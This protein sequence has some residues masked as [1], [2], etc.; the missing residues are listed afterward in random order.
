[1]NRL[2]Y[3]ANTDG[4]A[5]YYIYDE[6]GLRQAQLVYDTATSDFSDPSNDIYYYYQGLQVELETT[7]TGTPIREFL[8]G[9][10]LDQPVAQIESNGSVYYY[11]QNALGSVV[12]LTDTTGSVVQQ[13]S[14]TVH[15]ERTVKSASGTILDESAAL[16]VYAFTGRRFDAPFGLHYYRQRY[17]SATLGR[18]ISTDPLD[19]VDG[20][21]LYAYVGGSPVNG[22]DPLGQ[23]KIELT[24][25]GRVLAEM[26]VNGSVSMVD[27]GG[28]TQTRHGKGRGAWTTT[29]YSLRTGHTEVTR[30][31]NNARSN[32][33]R[34]VATAIKEF[35]H[36]TGGSFRGEKL[37]TGILLDHLSQFNDP[38][39]VPRAPDYAS[40]WLS[41]GGGA[42]GMIGGIYTAVQSGGLSAVP[43]AFL[44]LQ[45]FDVAVAGVVQ[46]MTGES[47]RTY[48]NRGLN[49]AARQVTDDAAAAQRF[50]DIAEF[51][52]GFINIGGNA[53]KAIATSSNQVGRLSNTVRNSGN[54]GKSTVTGGNAIRGAPAVRAATKTPL[55]FSQ[56][57]A[58]AFFSAEGKF[59]GR[60]IAGVA[61]DLRA[62][63]LNAADVP[64]EFIVRDGQRL[65]VNT[66]SSLALRQAGIPES[67]WNL[68]N[69]TGVEA[70][71]QNITNR[72]LRNGLDDAGTDVLRI[73]GQGQ[74]ASTLSPDFA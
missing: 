39:Y 37:A 31:G 51:A 3:A 40:G 65:I 19:Y 49:A 11:H 20:M 56:N 32:S 2:V 44:I 52:I 48:T 62:G 13:Y 74:G 63:A 73:T 12:A 15:G 53:G 66:R 57:T 16:S 67:Q 18:F 34:S 24:D 22:I 60:S 9:A 4:D 61:D 8:L 38:S 71:E 55:N 43:S 10:M 64:V 25:S 69:R 47:T 6:N 27:I 50:A 42:L 7:G 17:Y 45:S 26:E 35:D 70:V 68:I 59:A 30:R 23:S 72:L 58:S 41:V 5:V 33:G 28:Y 36:I 14:Y 21:N 46:G 29:T 54:L 1:M